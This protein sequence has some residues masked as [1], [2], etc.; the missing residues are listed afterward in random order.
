M[1]NKYH[2]SSLIKLGIVALTIAILG[3]IRAYAIMHPPPPDERTIGGLLQA[4]SQDG[5]NQDKSGQVFGAIIGVTISVI[6]YS[7]PMA[8]G[9]YRQSSKLNVIMILTLAT[10][11]F[12][13]PALGLIIGLVLVFWPDKKTDVPQD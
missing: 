6:I 2:A 11:F 3:G 13:Y 5:Q 4:I 9:V 12:G 10:L 8:V 1:K 7:L